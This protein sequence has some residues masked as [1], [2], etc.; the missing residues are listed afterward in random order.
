M[1]KRPARCRGLPAPIEYHLANAYRNLDVHSRAE[2]TRI[3]SAQSPATP[4]QQPA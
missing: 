1:T 4:Q 2:L 3:I